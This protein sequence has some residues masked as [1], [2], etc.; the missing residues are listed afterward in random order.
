MS[1]KLEQV[2]RDLIANVKP[3]IFWDLV[4]VCGDKID[5]KLEEVMSQGVLIMEKDP[6]KFVASLIAAMDR[7]VPIIIGN[8]QWGFAERTSFQQQFSP[9]VIFGTG[10]IFE[11]DQSVFKKEDQ[12]SILIPT[13]GTS[14]NA[15][16]FAIHRWES[17]EA[18]SFMVQSFL[19]AKAINSICCLPLFHVSGLMQIIRAIVTKGQILF[20]QLDD[21]EAVSQIIAVEDYCLS[22]VP[23]QLDRLISKELVF[24]K[25][26]E[27][28]AIFLGGAAANESLLTKAKDYELPIALSYGMTETAGMICAQSKEEFLSGKVSSGKPL[29]SVKL[30]FN[31]KDGFK[32]IHLF[33]KS[34]FYGY[35]RGEASYERAEGF[36]TNDY[37]QLLNDGALAIEGRV[38]NWIISGGEKINPK[39]IENSLIASGYVE[40]ALVIGKD[41]KEWGQAIVAILLQKSDSSHEVLIDSIKEYLRK[42]LANYKLPK[43]YV[44]VD[45]LPISENGKQD[46]G[47]LSELLKSLTF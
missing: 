8:H 45:E 20:S 41:S 27:F 40:S 25:M 23:T 39:E 12:G 21:L 34:L 29:F 19:D 5:T 9:A 44:L 35:W 32:V 42:D 47:R 30:E 46:K 1:F 18:Q 14:Q 37:G 4:R 16:R 7:N 28:K 13:G 17:L 2:R 43:A 33:S 3:E 10:E 26:R 22:L 15:L 11:G 6:Q 24:E 31:S 38:D 36:S